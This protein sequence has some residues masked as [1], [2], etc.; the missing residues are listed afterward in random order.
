MATKLHHHVGYVLM[1]PQPIGPIAS[2]PE[3]RLSFCR[4]RC[5]PAE[6]DS[7]VSI[8][9][10]G[11]ED[12]TAIWHVLK[13][14]VTTLIGQTYTR[15]Q[16]EAW[17]ADEAPETLTRHLALGRSAFVAESERR[18][19]GFSRFYR[20]ELEALYVHP[21]W[22]GH[23]VG[24]LLLRAVESTASAGGV[25]SVCLDAALNAVPFYTSAGYQVLGPS[26]PLFDSGVPLPCIRMRKTL[27]SDGRQPA[28]PALSPVS[29]NRLRLPERLRPVPWPS[30][31]RCYRASLD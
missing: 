19:I 24:E 28:V 18:V 8:R 30:R 10:A 1:T 5:L 17:I 13:A 4:L 20:P 29:P 25:K 3:T 23:G 26:A 14:A 11:P 7:S 31:A 9:L 27:S 2:P 22:A 6:N 15:V 12:A 21:H 16:I